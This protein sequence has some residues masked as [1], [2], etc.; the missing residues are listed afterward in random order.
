MNKLKILALLP[1]LALCSCGAKRNKYVGT[2]QFRMG[3]TDGNHMEVTATITD[4]DDEKVQGY[5]VMKVNADLG[6]DLNPMNMLDELEAASARLEP[7]IPVDEINSLLSAFRTEIENID[8]I[9]LYYKV[10][11]NSLEKQGYRLEVGTHFIADLFASIEQKQPTLSEILGDLKSLIVTT[12]FTDENLYIKPETSKYIFNAF[13][14]KKA[15]TF[16]VP[17]SMDDL[18]YQ[19]F[20]YGMDYNSLMISPDVDMEKD[21]VNRMPGETGEKRYGTHPALVKENNIVILDEVAKVNSEFEYEFSKTPLFATNDTYDFSELGRLILEQVDGH[22]QLRIKKSTNEPLTGTIT[23]YLGSSREPIKVTLNE[24]GVCQ[25]T[26]DGKKGS[27]EGFDDLD[28]NHFFFED[29]VYD[30]FVF[31]DFNIVDVGLTKVEA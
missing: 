24:K 4:E 9:P 17:V 12:G 21:Y 10:S 20:W 8:S 1:A 30:P 16:Q 18:K 7:F 13:V 6:D 28:G 19:M 25:V 22:Y 26:S 27:I 23:G 15:L 31:R 2:Y 3:K 14:N 29:I 5:K 11:E